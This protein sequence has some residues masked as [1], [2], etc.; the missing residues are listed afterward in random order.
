MFGP[1]LYGMTP[2]L[3]TTAKSLISAYAPLSGTIVSDKFRQVLVQGSDQLGPIGHGWAP[4]W[5]TSI[6]RELQMIC[7]RFVHMVEV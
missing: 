1:D 6:S 5:R 2:N 7:S 3:I 4:V